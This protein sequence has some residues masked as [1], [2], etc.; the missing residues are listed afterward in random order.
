M[1]RDEELIALVKR[2]KM[3]VD[4]IE[5]DRR[6]CLEAVGLDP[7]T[8]LNKTEVITLIDVAFN[9]LVI[10]NADA[11]A[12]CYPRDFAAKN[13]CEFIT[14]ERYLVELEGL[15]LNRVQLQELAKDREQMFMSSKAETKSKAERLF[16]LIMEGPFVDDDELK[17]LVDS[18]SIY[19]FMGLVLESGNTARARISA[20]AKLAKDPR[21]VEK[22]SVYE[23]WLLWRSEPTR[24]S[25]KAEFAR[26]MLDKYGSLKSSTV[27]ERWCRE[28]EAKL[29]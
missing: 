27:I 5:E 7:S 14:L 22:A 21:Q 15:G 16:D 13:G 26:D 19:E 12:D 11:E 28:W 18:L 3:S 24:Y 2:R 8:A 25:G 4:E 17:E 20:Q 6:A 9:Q 29:S 23:L 10:N 1:S